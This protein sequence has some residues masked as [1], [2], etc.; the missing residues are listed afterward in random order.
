MVLWTICGLNCDRYYAI[1]APLHYTHIISPKKIIIG[2]GAGWTISITLSIPPIFRVA[3]YDYFPGMGGC[4]PNFSVG[5][6]TLWYSTFYTAFT[7]LLPAT[8][9]ICCNLKVRYHINFYTG[10][11]YVNSLQILMIARYHRHRIAS[12]IYEVTLSAQVTITHQRNP[13]FVPTV[14]APSS[15][16]PKF[17]S[18]NAIY[19]VFQLVGSFLILYLPYYCIILWESSWGK[20][21]KLHQHYYTLAGALLISTIPMNAFLYGIKSK[22]LRKT[23]QNYWRKKQTK[24]EVNHEIQARTPSTCGSRRPSLTPLAFLTKPTLQRRLSETLLDIHRGSKGSH[25]SKIKRIA[26]EYTWRPSSANSLNSPKEEIS[27]K[28]ITHTASCNTLKVPEDDVSTIAEDE[29]YIKIKNKGSPTKPYAAN[30]LIQ[31][32][33]GIEQEKITKKAAA[34]QNALE[35][36]P[37]RSPMILITRAFSEESDKSSNGSPAKEI[38]KNRSSSANTLFER[39]WRQLRYKDEDSDNDNLK[40]G[41]NTTTKPLLDNSRSSDSSETSETSSGKIFMALDQKIPNEDME[42]TEEHHLLTWSNNK[43]PDDRKSKTNLLKQSLINV[44][45]QEVVL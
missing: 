22:T 33:F 26:S 35:G 10:F 17:R 20:Q 38:T 4:A 27:S 18:S 23:F 21:E 42:T 13:F 9:I 30:M 25:K 45:S 36:T 39:K 16:G 29:I 43:K 37:K 31:K 14:T 32:I 8:V 6:G 24:N 12:A 15:G 28:K 1:A 5:V 34:V 3:S 2:L 44:P 11:L 40:S 7:L 19:T 41:Y